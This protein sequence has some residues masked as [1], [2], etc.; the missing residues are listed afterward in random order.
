MPCLVDM[1]SPRHT[2]TLLHTHMVLDL[3]PPPGARQLL[4]R[5][6]QARLLAAAPRPVCQATQAAHPLG[7]TRL[8]PL[9]RL[10]RLPAALR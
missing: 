10:G 3:L 5:T 4:R 2:I 9:T 8:P 7:H 1:A 6:R